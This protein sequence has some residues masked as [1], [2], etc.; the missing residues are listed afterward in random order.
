MAQK[1]INQE[2]TIYVALIK[3]KNYIIFKGYNT[4]NEAKAFLDKFI[5][6]DDYVEI[7]VNG[8]FI[9]V[10]YEHLH[11]VDLDNL[12]I[13]FDENKSSII[14]IGDDYLHQLVLNYDEYINGD[15]PVRYCNGDTLD[16]RMLNL[17]IVH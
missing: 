11:L 1:M 16:C 17:K 15:A 8:L 14:K 3:T 10:E 6:F 5:C 13:N 9:T 4:H 12:T 7:N 2:G